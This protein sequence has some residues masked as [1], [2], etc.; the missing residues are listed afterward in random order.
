LKVQHEEGNL[1]IGGCNPQLDLIFPGVLEGDGIDPIQQ[2]DAVWARNEKILSN[3]LAAVA[4][5]HIGPFPRKEAVFELARCLH[6]FRRAHGLILLFIPGFGF[7]E[8]PGF[9]DNPIHI[10]HC[11][12]YLRKVKGESGICTPGFL[13]G[14]HSLFALSNLLWG[15]IRGAQSAILH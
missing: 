10:Q 2:I 11:K 4:F 13:P 8:R 3:F 1:G 9:F 7:G 5:P 15:P 14:P 12:T 6:P